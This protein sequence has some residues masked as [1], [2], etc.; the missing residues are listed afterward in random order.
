MSAVLRCFFESC[1]SRSEATKEAFN[2]FLAKAIDLYD[3]AVRRGW[4]LTIRTIESNGQVCEYDKKV[5]EFESAR[6]ALIKACTEAR[7]DIGAVRSNL[8]PDKVVDIV[9]MFRS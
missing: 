3:T 6:D 1:V 9:Q 8:V 7:M 5:G 4:N 2:H